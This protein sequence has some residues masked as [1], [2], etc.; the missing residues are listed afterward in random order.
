MRIGGRWGQQDV[1]PCRSLSR[2]DRRSEGVQPLPIVINARQP[3][4]QSEFSR[5]FALISQVSGADEGMLH[6]T[7][8]APDVSGERQ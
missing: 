5:D 1:G 7:S 4:N 6:G 2:H 3:F 8:T